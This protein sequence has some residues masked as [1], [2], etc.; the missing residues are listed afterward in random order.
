MVGFDSDLNPSHNGSLANEAHEKF[1]YS[2]EISVKVTVPYRVE[3][4]L[5]ASQFIFHASA[6]EL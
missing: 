3:F 2:Q 1:I 5:K 6:E 4:P